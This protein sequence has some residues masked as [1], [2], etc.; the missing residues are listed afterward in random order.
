MFSP[1]GRYL[2]LKQADQQLRLWEF[3]L[4]RILL[5]APGVVKKAAFSLDSQFFAAVDGS[6]LRLWHLSSINT[7]G[8]TEPILTREMKAQ[9]NASPISF[10]S[11][12]V[13]VLERRNA[14]ETLRYESKGLR[15]ADRHDGP[16][17]VSSV[18]GG[19]VV[20]REIDSPYPQRLLV[21]PSEVTV[22][23]ASNKYPS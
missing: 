16:T 1:D 15:E 11:D 23:H 21:T 18:E 9:G 3:S 17:V 19:R 13:V 12:G 4:D 10:S 20:T 14:I 22:R 7:G 6:Q 2:V 8:A 5:S